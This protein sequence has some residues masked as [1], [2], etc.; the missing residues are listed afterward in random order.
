MLVLDAIQR[1]QVNLTVFLGLY[2]DDTAA[3]GP[4]FLRQLGEIEAAL[5]AFGTSYVD[6]I[7]VGNEYILNLFN[8]AKAGTAAAAAQKAGERIVLANI[9]ATR[10]AITALNLSSTVL[11]GTADAGSMITATLSAASDFIMANVH[12]FFSGVS[13]ADAAAWTY[14]YLNTDTPSIALKAANHPALYAAEVGWPSAAE[15]NGSLTLNGSDASM[16]NM[17][18]F[19]DTFVCASNTNAT[20]SF[21]FEA[22]DETWKLGAYGGAESH[23][24]LMYANR[25]LKDVTIPNCPATFE[26]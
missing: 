7:I 15:P 8:D 13:I 26:D 16:T 10:T 18:T 19:L 17:Q 25:T 14:N 11:I 4:V 6:G 5:K 1:T 20:K 9:V 2:F 12:A 3:G 23:W 24:G 22:F 21:W